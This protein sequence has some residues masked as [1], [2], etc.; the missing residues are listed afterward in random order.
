MTEEELK[1]INVN[2]LKSSLL[3]ACFH[4]EVW[5]RCPYCGSAT[6]IGYFPPEKDGYFIIK[7]DNCKNIYKDK[8]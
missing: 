4:G 6:E 8:R 5:V 2:E 7:C 1:N 3:G